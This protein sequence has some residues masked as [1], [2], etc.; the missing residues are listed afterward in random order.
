MIKLLTFR[1]LFA[2]PFL[3]QI[4]LAQ[5]YGRGDYG[6]CTYGEGEQAS[7]STSIIDTIVDRLPNTGPEILLALSS[8]LAI[9]AAVIVYR[10]TRA[11]S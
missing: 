6:T 5:A 8:L 4:A 2:W 9:I 7:C 11:T 10:R 3:P 1:L